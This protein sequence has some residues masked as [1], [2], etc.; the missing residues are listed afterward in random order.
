M[1]SQNEN[2]QALLLAERQALEAIDAA[3]KSRFPERIITACMVKY[4]MALTP[5]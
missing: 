2:V 4:T 3:R 5:V 1:A